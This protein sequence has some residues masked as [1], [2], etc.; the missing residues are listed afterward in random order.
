[1]L[2]LIEARL[3]TAGAPIVAVELAENLDALA[4]GTAAKS[5]TAFLVPWSERGGDNM[6][7]TG[8]FR[9]LVDAQFLVAVVI[10]YHADAK[11]ADRVALFESMKASI[12]GVLAGWQYDEHAEPM[13][14]VGGESSPLGNNVTVYVQTWQTSRYLEGADA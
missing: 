3:L 6:I 10:R 7:A 1:M 9:Q 11:G 13:A 12:E 4:R 5:G 2:D 14:L 8:G